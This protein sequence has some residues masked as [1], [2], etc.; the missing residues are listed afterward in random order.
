MTEHTHTQ[1]VCQILS[2]LEDAVSCHRSIILMAG[3]SSESIFH[4]SGGS[5]ADDKLFQGLVCL[6]QFQTA[7]TNMMSTISPA[8]WED[9]ALL[10]LHLQDFLGYVQYFTLLVKFHENQS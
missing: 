5:Q 3:K 2:S 1:Y 6:Y 4:V 7:F 10:I 9:R 8:I